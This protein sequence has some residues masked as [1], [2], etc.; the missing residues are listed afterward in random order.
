VPYFPI[1]ATLHTPLVCS[2]H[3]LQS[4]WHLHIAKATERSA[5]RDG[6][7][8]CFGKEYLVI[9]RVGVKETQELTPDREVYNLVNTGKV[10]WIRRACLV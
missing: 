6:R 3:V 9:T 10:E 4:E 7:L 2:P 1:Q 8:V 5:K